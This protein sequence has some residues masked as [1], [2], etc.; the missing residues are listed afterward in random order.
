MDRN[1][2]WPYDPLGELYFPPEARTE[3]IICSL[4]RMDDFDGHPLSCRAERGIHSAHAANSKSSHDAVRAYTAWVALLHR[5]DTAG[6]GIS[7]W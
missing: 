7:P 1:Q 6:H 3:L 2:T 5:L 4:R